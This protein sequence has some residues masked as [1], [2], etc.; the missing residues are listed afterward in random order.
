MSVVNNKWYSDDDSFQFHIE[1]KDRLREILMSENCK[2]LK[3]IK[4]I[5]V[6]KN[7]LY[8]T[9]ENER[10]LFP[11]TDFIRKLAEE[12]IKYSKT[13]RVP[14]VIK[15]KLDDMVMYIAA[16]Y[17]WDSAYMERGGGVIQ[18]IY[19]NKAHWIGK[20]KDEKV[21]FLKAVRDWWNKCDERDRTREWLMNLFNCMI[22]RYE[23]QEFWYKSINWV[24][25]YIIEH[26]SEWEKSGQFDPVVWFPKG[27]GQINNLVHA[28]RS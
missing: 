18:F 22:K 23:K 2:E 9:E 19:Y 15:L 5:I 20:T 7:W 28:G 17:R 13:I 25:D 12:Y 27:R 21:K 26:E 4:D 11:N 8:K 16:L 3:L 10:D 24:F 6:N 1:N 14:P